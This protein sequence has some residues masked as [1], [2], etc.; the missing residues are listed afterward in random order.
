VA[1]HTPGPWEVEM[2]LSPPYAEAG[3]Y[4]YG[5]NEDHI[6]TVWTSGEATEGD[7][8]LI[9]AAPAMRA[10]LQQTTEWIELFVLP[11]AR[12][13]EACQRFIRR[14]R[15]LLASIDGT[16]TGVKAEPV[17]CPHA[18]IRQ[19]SVGIATRRCTRD[20]GHSGPH[21]LESWVIA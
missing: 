12:N 9:A 8:R 6:A 13:P 10:E 15:A 20:E 16:D 3:S 7:A 5:K 4:I 14:N 2:F 21:S 17:R 19:S 18:E 11:H 1:E